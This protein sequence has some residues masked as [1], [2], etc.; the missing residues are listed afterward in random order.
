MASTTK[1]GVA[2]DDA[3]NSVFCFPAER[4]EITKSGNEFQ[5]FRRVFLMR[6]FGLAPGMAAAVADLAFETREAR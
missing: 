6:R 3:L 2:G 5:D 4:S 1:K